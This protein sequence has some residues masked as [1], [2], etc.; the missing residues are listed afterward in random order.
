MSDKEDTNAL[1]GNE[2]NLDQVEDVAGG[3]DCGATVTAG[4]GGVNISSPVTELGDSVIRTY[5]GLIEA[6][7]YAI[8][9]IAGSLK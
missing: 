3:A 7:S 5:E 8:E 9:R 6:T 4:T 2:L 1:A